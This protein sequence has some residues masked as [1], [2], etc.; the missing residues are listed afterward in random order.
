MIYDQNRDLNV[1]SEGSQTGAGVSGL[2]C[3]M[4]QCRLHTLCH[5]TEAIDDGMGKEGLGGSP[6]SIV[7]G[8]GL[9]YSFL[10]LVNSRR[11]AS[12]VLRTACSN[13]HGTRRV[14]RTVRAST[15]KRGRRHA[16]PRR[17]FSKAR[18]VGAT[19][20]SELGAFTRLTFRISGRR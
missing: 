7:C 13:D 2:E 18:G 5:A 14:E 8:S 4:A 12:D 10:R 11:D 20:N 19:R 9:R 15:Q 1:A 3:V 17:P 16:R 6:P